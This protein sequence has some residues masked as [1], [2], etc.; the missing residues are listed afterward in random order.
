MLKRFLV[1]FLTLGALSL[2]A[3]SSVFAVTYST[4]DFDIGT[5]TLY[6]RQP[7]PFGQTSGDA[8]ANFSSPSDFPSHPAFS[9]QSVVSLAATSVVINS[10]K[11]S[12]QFLW[13]STVNQDHL[14]MNF[15]T[16]VT[17]ITMDFKTAELHDPGPGGTGSPIRLS[18]SVNSS[19]TP[20]GSP[21]ISYGTE[22]PFDTYPEG[23]L[24]FNASGQ[25]FDRVEIDLPFISQGATGFILDN[26][27]VGITAVPEFPATPIVSLSMLLAV[28]FSALASRKIM[29]NAGAPKSR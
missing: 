27:V 28:F 19:S 5:P 24:T 3:V 16:N 11:F 8:T 7:T 13:P 2:L 29:K 17:S 25:G 14:V 15:S 23:T 1:C 10:T 20:V 9:V 22:T 12:G 18:A 4:F 26:I 21:V 6:L